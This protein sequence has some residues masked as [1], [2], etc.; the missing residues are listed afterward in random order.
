MGFGEPPGWELRGGTHLIVPRVEKAGWIWSL[1]STLG[2]DLSPF[3]I[4]LWPRCPLPL[5]SLLPV[6]P[7]GNQ[8]CHPAP[9][10]A[11]SEGRARLQPPHTAAGGWGPLVPPWGWGTNHHLTPVPR[12]L[13]GP[14]RIAHP[15]PSPAG[16]G[17]AHGMAGEGFP[18]SWL[19]TASTEPQERWI[20][21]EH[22]C[23]RTPGMPCSPQPPSAQRGCWRLGT[24]SPSWPFPTW[25]TCPVPAR[26]HHAPCSRPSPRGG[27]PASA[28]AVST[29]GAFALPPCCHIFPHL[30]SPG[31]IGRRVPPGSLIYSGSA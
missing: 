3:P 29:P 1:L 10:S 25:F 17:D 7:R 28:G 15:G 30:P 14:L 2:G 23:N 8:P 21:G 24:E 9:C 12:G 26:T 11:V 20:L 13:L 18:L 5:W 19:A 16:P 27:F 31:N 4:L 22:H 6:P